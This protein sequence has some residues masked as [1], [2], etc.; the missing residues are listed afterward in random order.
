[1]TAPIAVALDTSDLETAVSWAAASG[2]F[3]STVKVGL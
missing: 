2:P 1:M 3:V